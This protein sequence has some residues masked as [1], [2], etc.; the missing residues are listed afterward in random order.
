VATRGNLPPEI[1]EPGPKKKALAF[2]DIAAPSAYKQYEGA[3][4]TLQKLE[5]NK[6]STEEQRAEQW[7]LMSGAVRKME[8]TMNEYDKLTGD[9]SLSAKAYK[10]AVDR[11]LNNVVSDEE[12][13]DGK[14][15]KIREQDRVTREWEANKAKREI[16][17]KENPDPK[18]DTEDLA[19]IRMF[20]TDGKATFDLHQ[21]K[22]QENDDEKNIVFM[23]M[24]QVKS[25][26]EAY[27]MYKLTTDMIAQAEKEDVQSKAA[28]AQASAAA[29]T[30][31]PTNA[32]SAQATVTSRDMKF[33]VSAATDT[34]SKPNDDIIDKGTPEP[35]TKPDVTPKTV[36]IE[37]SDEKGELA[38]KGVQARAVETKPEPKTVA[39][40]T[41]D[42]KEVPANTETQPVKNNV[43]TKTPNVDTAPEKVEVT[44]LAEGTIKVSTQK[45]IHVAYYLPNGKRENNYVRFPSSEIR[46]WNIPGICSAER[47]PEGWMIRSET[48][49]GG[50]LLIYA[51][52]A[53]HWVNLPKSQ[54]KKSESANDPDGSFALLNEIANRIRTE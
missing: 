32:S 53:D 2:I 50:Q 20:L 30:Q 12:D 22:F 10:S 13:D 9:Y 15:T 46:S 33:S 31:N 3:Y 34:A 36:A 49:V 44:A 42:K 8:R 1:T 40:D 38:K 54:E 28:T 48:D 6:D 52:E 21:P 41:P 47:T 19:A 29:D 45:T 7:A 27:E 43:D 11:Y 25:G 24:D 14:I 4:N 16:F 23:A 26:V 18:K 5:E 35:T 39:V 51:G 37:T 17:F